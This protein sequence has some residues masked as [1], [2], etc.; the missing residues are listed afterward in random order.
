MAGLKSHIRLKN[1][2]KT[3]Y[4]YL[5][6]FIDPSN[7]ISHYKAAVNDKTTTYQRYDLS[8]SYG[9]VWKDQFIVVAKKSN[10][11]QIIYPIDSGG[12]KM[13]WIRQTQINKL[14]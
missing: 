12:W 5:S 9:W 1:G 8:K 14:D 3:A 7:A 10:A 11:C 13:G 2:N 6:E 4:C